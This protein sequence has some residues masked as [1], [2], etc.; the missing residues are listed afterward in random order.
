MYGYRLIDSQK[1]WDATAEPWPDFASGR[2]VWFTNDDSFTFHYTNIVPEQWFEIDN[3]KLA[4]FCVIE[5]AGEIASITTVGAPPGT[6]Q[7]RSAVVGLP[8]I[9]PEL[10]ADPLFATHPVTELTGA[11]TKISSF[12]SSG[13]G[14]PTQVTSS[15]PP[16]FGYVAG[17]KFDANVVP[18]FPFSG[19]AISQGDR[20]H[21]VFQ[22]GAIGPG[23][24][25][26]SA[27]RKLYW[28]FGSY[29]PSLGGDPSAM[30]I[31]GKI[32][33]HLYEFRENR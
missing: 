17:A 4:D 31:T 21:H 26:C 5:M 13:L 10:E 28:S 15:L 18:G 27:F 22:I 3:S 9:G 29:N 6:S 32:Y 8:N 33:A 20:F 7:V 16:Y 19:A 25:G 24:L 12:C 2:A 23:G 30:S 11:T 1:L 14:L